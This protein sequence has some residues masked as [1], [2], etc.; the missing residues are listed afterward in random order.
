MQEPMRRIPPAM[1]HAEWVY[2]PN[3]QWQFVLAIYGAKSQ[4][5]LAKGDIQDNRIGAAERGAML[6]A[7]C[8]LGTKRGGCLWM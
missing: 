5:R 3:K 6:Q 2:R 4:Q 8:V 7:I 1:L